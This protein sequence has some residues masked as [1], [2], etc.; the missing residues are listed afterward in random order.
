[1]PMFRLT[2]LSLAAVALCGQGAEAGCRT[3]VGSADMVTTDLAKF[4]A[5]AALKNAIEAHGLKPSGEIKL[6]CREDTFT[7]YCKASRPAC[8]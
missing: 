6:T 2:L 8:N 7:T 5:N 3:I 4:M 1:M